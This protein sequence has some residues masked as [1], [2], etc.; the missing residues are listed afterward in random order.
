MARLSSC[1]FSL[2]NLLAL[3]SGCFAIGSYLYFQIH[4]V[5]IILI[6]M[7]LLGFLG[8]IF[9]FTC[10]LWIYSLVALLV[11]VGLQWNGIRAYLID[12][13][14]CKRLGNTVYKAQDLYLKNLTPVQN[15]TFWVVP[16]SGEVPK[17]R[18]CT[19]WSHKLEKLRY[20]CNTCKAAVI[21]KS[22]KT[23][24]IFA[25][26]DFIDNIALLLIV[27]AVSCCTRNHILFD[28][29]YHRICP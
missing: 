26:L 20:N 7:S 11:L 24:R 13:Q 16:K 8:T 23:W 1:L 9:R 12:Q 4:G 25:I 15:A 27:Y 17:E 2:F 6:V 14:V 5:L 29:K 3:V 28:I 18:D 22:K 19:L 21:K 10:L